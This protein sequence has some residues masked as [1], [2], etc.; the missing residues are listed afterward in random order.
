MNDLSRRGG[1]LQGY[2][3]FIYVLK[4]FAIFGVVCAHGTA[5]PGYFS[6]VSQTVSLIIQGIGAIG[7][8]IF[9]F[10]SG[11]LFCRGNSKKQK[12]P[13]FL[14]K[15][16]LEI[17]IPWIVSATLVY[18]YVA[19]RKGG[20]IQ[21]YLLSV[22]GYLSSYW[23]M[24]V[25]MV[26]YLVFYAAFYYKR[27]KLACYGFIMAALLSV[28]LRKAGIIAEDAL[29]IYLNSLNWGI[30]FSAGILVSPQFNVLLELAKKFRGYLLIAGTMIIVL[31]GV[32]GYGFSYYRWYYI[33]IELFFIFGA[34]SAAE[35]FKDS[36]LLKY[37]GKQSFAI[38]LY[39]Q[40]PWAGLIA[41]IADQYDFWLFVVMR[42]VLVMTFT[43]CT[44]HAGYEFFKLVGKERQYSGIT[45]F[46]R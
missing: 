15:K 45:A 39:G 22:A 12:F 13:T 19:L 4:A 8:G 17:G 11:F 34:V 14:K 31:L 38:Y 28:L 30:F 10:I 36:N 42:P 33:L 20:S 24:N 35:W 18:L 37:I 5:V 26:L 21:G 6:A 43:L 29:G 40:L 1:S 41:H 2:E 3:N 46:N 27:E 44:L 9:F 25:L 7:A 23:F 16:A 32:F